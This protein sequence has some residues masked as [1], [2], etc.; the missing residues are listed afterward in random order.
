[1]KTI[2]I[3]IYGLPHRA[4]DFQKVSSGQLRGQIYDLVRRAPFA[5]RVVVSTLPADVMDLSYAS[6]PFLRVYTVDE[7]DREDVCDVL[8]R[9]GYPIQCL[10]LVSYFPED[11]LSHQ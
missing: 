9:L 7:T 2:N 1:M 5:D 4:N 6:R 11:S 3:E 10:R 8:S